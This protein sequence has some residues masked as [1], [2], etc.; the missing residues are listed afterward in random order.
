MA[1][2]ASNEE[3]AK[4]AQEALAAAAAA[5]EKSKRMLEGYQ[6]PAQP[7]SAADASAA[8]SGGAEGGSAAAPDMAGADIEVNIATPSQFKA[9]HE[10]SK[11]RWARPNPTFPPLPAI[12]LYRM[13]RTRDI[14]PQFLFRQGTLKG[15]QLKGLQWLANLYDQGLNGILADEMG[16]GKTVQARGTGKDRRARKIAPRTP[17][18][19]PQ[20]PR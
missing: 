4:M 8:A 14:H 19:L 12:C 5:S 10:I 2:D 16:L 15:Y 18:S 9:R 3:A 1:A 11:E 7:P 13:S 17:H 6:M 20:R